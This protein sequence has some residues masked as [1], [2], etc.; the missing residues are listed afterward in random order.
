MKLASEGAVRDSIEV[1]TMT[2]K[3]LGE[4]GLRYWARINEVCVRGESDLYSVADLVWQIE[5]I[6]LV[7][8]RPSSE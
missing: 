2:S 6:T 5:A 3:K 7:Q 8:K 4:T 1:D